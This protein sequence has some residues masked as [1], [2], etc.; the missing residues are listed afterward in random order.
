VLNPGSN[1]LNVTFTPSDTTD[2]KSQTASVALTVNS[3]TPSGVAIL[4]PSAGATVSGTI[5]VSGQITVTL[6]AAGSYLMVDG[7][8]IGT[9]RL[10]SGPFLYPLNTTT[11]SNGQ[12]VLRLWAHDFGNNTDLSPPVTITVAN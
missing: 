4:S 5:T 6:D 11:L 2:Y 10:T 9:Q 12:H 3:S 7:V 8:E 1:T